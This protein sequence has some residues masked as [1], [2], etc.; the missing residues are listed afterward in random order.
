MNIKTSNGFVPFNKTTLFIYGNPKIGKTT[1]LSG[2]PNALLLATEPGYK[3]L[4]IDYEDITSWQQ[5]KDETVPSLL[6]DKSLKKKYATLCIDTIDLLANLCIA[7]VCGEADIDH[8]SE[9]KWGKAYDRLKKEFESEINKLFMSDYGLVFTSH[10]KITE[11]SNFSGSISKVI[12]TLNNQCR[13][14]LIPK[15]DII[16]CL[17]IKTVKTEDGK[18][19]DLRIITFAPSELW[20]AGDRTGRLPDEIR[21]YKDASKTYKQLKDAYEKGRDTKGGSMK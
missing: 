13:S 19:K 6:K 4:K 11:L 21:V 14:I 3:S 16:G 5:F 18:Y 8:I 9:E 12:P 2:F 7:Y 17:K 10:T 15:I 1:M 20:E